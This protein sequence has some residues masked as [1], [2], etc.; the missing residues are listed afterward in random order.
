MSVCACGCAW[1]SEWECEGVKH[2]T[3]AQWLGL[4]SQSHTPPRVIL[5]GVMVI[6]SLVWCPLHR[7]S[8][9]ACLDSVRPDPTFLPWAS[10]PSSW[11]SDP[12]S[13]SLP[14][15]FRLFVLFLFSVNIDFLFWTCRDQLRFWSG[16]RGGWL[17]LLIFF[18]FLSWILVFELEKNTYKYIYKQM[19]YL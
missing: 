17:G 18:F 14:T 8:P 9:Q 19:T 7:E 4:Q 10:S 2:C 3:R 5:A 12:Q 16:G 13:H 1:E 11:L 6:A 15:S